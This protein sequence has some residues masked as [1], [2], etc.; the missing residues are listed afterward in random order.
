MLCGMGYI[1][2]VRGGGVVVGLLVRVVYD[3]GVCSA[4]SIFF[5]YVWHEG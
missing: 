2:C 5:M 3:I 4:R 1:G